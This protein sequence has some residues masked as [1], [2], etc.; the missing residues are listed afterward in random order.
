MK[1]NSNN[2]FELPQSVF[3]VDTFTGSMEG[4]N[5]QVEAQH[6]KVLSDTMMIA[7][8]QSKAEYGRL[9]GDEAE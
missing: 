2:F 3:S 9:N 5:Y 6:F 8:P 1:V 7:I 4:L